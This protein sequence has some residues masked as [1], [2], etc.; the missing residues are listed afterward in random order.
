MCPERSIPVWASCTGQGKAETAYKNNKGRRLIAGERP[1]FSPNLAICGNAVEACLL[2]RR[3]GGVSLHHLTARHTQ[4]SRQK[5]L[6][7]LRCGFR[8]Y[9]GRGCRPV[10]L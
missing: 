7:A 10:P 6:V 2:F 4:R 9:H 1:S 5:I 8:S 3:A